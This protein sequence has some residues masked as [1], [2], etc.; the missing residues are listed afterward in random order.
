[1]AKQTQ[2]NGPPIRSRTN[3]MMS[4]AT[5]VL[6]APS[7]VPE[8]GSGNSSHAN[9]LSESCTPINRTRLAVHTRR[10]W[11]RCLL[12]KP[13]RSNLRKTP[14]PGCFSALQSN[15]RA[16]TKIVQWFWLHQSVTKDSWRTQMSS[17]YGLLS[18][19]CYVGVSTVLLGGDQY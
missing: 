5:F 13:S 1:M 14:G 15:W 17:W 8:W 4:T 16:C 19:R 9:D 3:I 7:I 6:S 2:R 18:D 12:G 10:L 11:R